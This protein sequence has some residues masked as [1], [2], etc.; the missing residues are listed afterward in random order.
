MKPNLDNTFMK[1]IK[2]LFQK[3]N[4][5]LLTNEKNVKKE[6]NDLFCVQF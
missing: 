3:A 1:S 2:Q 4:S 6:S 5:F